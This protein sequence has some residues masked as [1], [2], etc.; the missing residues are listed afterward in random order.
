MVRAGLFAAIMATR[1][2]DALLL[3]RSDRSTGKH[4]Q[5]MAKNPIRKVVTLLQKMAKKVEK[6]AETEKE[7]YDKFMCYCTN[8]KMNLQQSIEDSTAKVPQLQKDITEAQS[9]VEQLKLDLQKHQTH[10]AEA[11]AAMAEATSL[12]EK[13]NA[14]Y[15]KESAELGSYVKGVTVAVNAI[16]SGMSGVKLI[17]SSAQSAMLKT[18]VANSDVL[19]EDD[20]Q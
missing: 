19:T 3:T 12:R 13:E 15:A 7:L 18:A 14:A 1:G 10:R 16:E 6:E 4:G 2:A 11:K 8:G 17:Q 9:S 5:D 20:R